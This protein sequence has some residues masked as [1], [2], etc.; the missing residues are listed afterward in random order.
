MYRFLGGLRRHCFVYLAFCAS[1]LRRCH[2]SGGLSLCFSVCFDS[3][4]LYAQ[5]VLR[6]NT[7]RTFSKCYRK[8]AS[9]GSGIVSDNI[10]SYRNM[11]FRDPEH[12]S[13]RPFLIAQT[14]LR[15]TKPCRSLARL[16][17]E[18]VMIHFGVLTQDGAC[19]V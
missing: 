4:P 15:S 10:P 18:N 2:R 16:S 5:Y 17:G 3:L 8:D 6:E 11:T 19:I 12:G 9:T 14:I 7:W 13:Q 1:L